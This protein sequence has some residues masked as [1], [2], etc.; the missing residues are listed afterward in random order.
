MV[1]VGRTSSE[2]GVRGAICAQAEAAL[3]VQ[4]K[5]AEEPVTEADR[6]VSELCIARLGEQ[7]PA[8]VVL[9]EERPDDGARLTAARYWLVDPIDGTK[10]FIAGRAGYSV[11]IG[12]VS[13]GQPVLGLV[14]QPAAERLWIAQQGLGA[15]EVI[16]HEPPRRIAVSDL[17][18][19]AAARLVSSASTREE[20]VRKVRDK[21]GIRDELQVGSVGVKLCL[22][23]SGA[24][25]LYMNPAGRCKLWDTAAPSII[26][27]EAGGRLTDLRGEPLSYTGANLS[28]RRG[29]VASNGAPD[30]V[31]S[32]LAGDESNRRL[33]S[34]R[35]GITLVALALGFGI[36][37]AAG[38]QDITPGVIAV[39]VGA[40][41]IGNLASF[42]ASRKFG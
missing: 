6:A 23:A 40:L 20:L 30:L 9:S 17:A 2:G 25:D 11:M 34:L 1:A 33:S 7:F 42:A 12:L 8:D 37:E 3:P 21:A 10:D 18:Q 22:I 29:L 35:W 36:V 24:R 32:I 13:N 31:R 19:M 38:W 5:D 16:E 26:L 14:Y 27:T 15:F 39:L 4:W 41:G 28:H